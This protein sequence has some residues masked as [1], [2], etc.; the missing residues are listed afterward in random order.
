MTHCANAVAVTGAAV[1]RARDKED[2]YQSIKYPCQPQTWVLGGTTDPLFTEKTAQSNAAP[3][4]LN[5][6][7]VGQGACNVTHLQKDKT[8]DTILGRLG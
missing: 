6:S 3:P 4:K 1:P 2:G 7:I 5:D 8:A